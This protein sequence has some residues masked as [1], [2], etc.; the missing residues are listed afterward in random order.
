MVFNKETLGLRFLTAL[1]NRKTSVNLFPFLSLLIFSEG[2][3]LRI[4]FCCSGFIKDINAVQPAV[5]PKRKKKSK[6]FDKN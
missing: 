3:Q 5:L 6:Y 1:E 4:H 2:T